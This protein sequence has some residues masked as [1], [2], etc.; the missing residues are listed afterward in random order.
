MN[1]LIVSSYLPYPLFDGGTIRLYNLMKELQKKHTITLIC[2]KRSKQTE[3]DVEEVEKI[4][5]KVITVPR[6]KQWS[7]SNILKTGILGKSFLITGHTL[8]EMQSLIAKELE[9][10]SY[11]L[12][13]VETSYVFQNLPQTS[14]PVVL[15]EHNIE[16]MVYQKFMN[17][18]PFFLKPFLSLDIHKL[19]RTEESYWKKATKVV[20]VSDLEKDLVGKTGV[21]AD[22]VYNGVDLENF[23][24][25]DLALSFDKTP[26]QFLFIGNYKWLQ[27]RDAVR[28][29]L[30]DIW[31][32]IKASTEESIVLRIVGRDMPDDIKN[33]SDETV[34]IEENSPRR[35]P[36]IFAESFALLAPIR[37]GGGSQ[38]KIL[39]SM[40]VGTPVIT[41]SLGLSGLDVKKDSDLLVED[42][43]SGL[44]KAAIVLLTD[45][46]KYNELSVN[47]RKQIEEKY[48][49]S[50]IATSLDTIY[51]SVA[52]L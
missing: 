16:Y 4:C 44:T 34:I 20:T 36:E 35:T 31:P 41:T 39:E 32:K 47:G 9:T 30:Q 19:K 37:I 8:P 38:Y 21:N 46:K 10:N 18:A 14:L 15:V 52:K 2:E 1:I 50:K 49:W 3:K 25:K 22:V 42:D 7:I 27:N 40:A 26:K 28:W 6:R 29:I 17:K 45:N 23:V 24:M 33:W 43:E 13:H 11:D 5:K 12:I 51:R 48:D